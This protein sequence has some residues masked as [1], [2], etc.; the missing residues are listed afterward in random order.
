MFWSLSKII[1][2]VAAV[3]LLSFGAVLLLESDGI[4]RIEFANREISMTPLALLILAVLAV[5]VVWSLVFLLGL[6]Q[7]A[8]K[9]LIG[10]E[11]A[12]TRYLNR[13]RERKGYEALANSL[14]SLSS[15]EPKNAI[16][17]A[18]KAERYLS[19]PRSPE[20]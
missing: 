14:I 10:D 20:F 5:P 8:V 1:A 7:A 4:V 18:E 11:T 16:S 9:F 6:L 12:L 19:R 17:D 13:N 3:A 2:F 15:G